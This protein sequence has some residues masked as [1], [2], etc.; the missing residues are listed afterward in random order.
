MQQ[1]NFFKKL[2]YKIMNFDME[3]L[4]A[5][6]ANFQSAR[7]Q[8]VKTSDSTKWGRLVEVADIVPARNGSFIAI[9]SDNSRIPAD[10]LTDDL[11]MI[12]EGTEPLSID[13]IRS[14]NYVPSLKDDFKVAPEIPAEIAS[15]IIKSASSQPEPKSSFQQTVHRPAQAKEVPKPVN[16]GDL[17]GM[18]ALEDTDLTLSVKIKLPSKSLLKMMYSN[19]NDKADFLTRL[20]TYINN[21][22]TV[23]SIMESMDKQLNGQQKKKQ[24]NEFA[25]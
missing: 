1:L 11:Y 4:I 22:V 6:K 2:Y 8:W 5:L 24:S 16:S 17:F 3:A 20:S 12:T 23:E 14:I 21:N 13:Q 25:Q 18:F 9:L 19:S 15:E 10:Q 7:F